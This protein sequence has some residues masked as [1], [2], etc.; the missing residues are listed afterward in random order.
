M[1]AA[2]AFLAWDLGTYVDALLQ[3]QGY[4]TRR[5][6]YRGIGSRAETNQALLAAAS[7]ARAEIVFGIKLGLIE[8][9]TIRRLREQG[10]FVL[11][12][13]VDCFDDR[14]PAQ[15]AK[16]VPEVDLFLTTA[17][18]MVD[19]YRALGDTPVHWVVEGVYL[20]AF[21]DVEP[22]PAQR[23]LYESDVSFVGNV[24][25]PPVPDAGL[26]Q[27][28][29]RLLSRVGERYSLKVWGPQGD[30]RVAD[31][32]ND[33][34]GKLIPWPAYHEELVKVCRCSRIVLGINTINTIEQYFSNRTYLTLASGGFHL[35]H[36]VP[37]L[38]R[39]FENRRHL[40]WFDSDEECLELLDEFSRNPELRRRIASEGRAFV[41]EHYAMSRQVERIL[42]MVEAH[43]D[44]WPH[45][46][47]LP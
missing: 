23:E 37:G 36:Y 21:P 8:P 39:M 46:Q 20:P 35:T 17:K 11:L 14:V 19:A 25:H 32:W 44:H 12:W 34:R 1:I 16:L 38:E 41:R 31:V 3:D 2:P 15:I 6:A 28:R 40:V 4:Q 7:A 27:R 42:S 13:H 47:H 43:R 33:T 22:P 29:L 45:P 5:F 24:L 9:T 10:S 18:G 26:A 30:G